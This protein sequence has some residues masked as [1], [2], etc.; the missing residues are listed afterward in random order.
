MADLPSRRRCRE[1]SLLPQAPS[2]LGVSLFY[3]EEWSLQSAVQAAWEGIIGRAAIAASSCA[4]GSA[5]T[6]SPADLA[7]IGYMVESIKSRELTTL[8]KAAA[9][10]Y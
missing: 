10:I 6:V 2:L 8:L 1:A 4:Q 3:I 7:K 5:V 9:N